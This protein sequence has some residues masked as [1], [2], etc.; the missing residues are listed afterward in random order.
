MN[1]HFSERYQN[2]N[3]EQKRAVDTIDGPVLVIAGPGS[4]KTEL[5]SLR[6]ANILRSTDTLPSS[7]LCLTFTDS[8]AV[9]MRKRLAGLI[10]QEAY[11]V[12]I[13][14]FHS[15]GSEIIN[16]NP[17]FFY[18]GA[19]FNP[20]DELVQYKI[21]EKILEALKHDTL[22]RSYN[23]EQGYTYLRDIIKKIGEL[24]KGGLDPKTLREILKENKNYLE[25]VNGFFPEIFSARM[26]KKTLEQIAGLL[27]KLKNVPMQPRTKVLPYKPIGTQLID[28]LELAFGD[29]MSGEKPDTKPITVW[30]NEYLKKND[31]NLP[32]LKELENIKKHFELCEIYEKYQQELRKEGYFDFDDMLMDTAEVI[33]KNPELRYNLQERYLYVLVDEFQD[34]NAVQMQLLDLLLDAEVNERRPNILAVGDDDQ[35]IYKFQGANLENILNFHQ[36]YLNPEL[37]VLQKNYRSTQPILDLVRKIILTGNERLEARLPDQIKK[38]LQSANTKLTNGEILEKEFQTGFEELAWIA[39]TIKHKIEVEKVPPSEIAVIAPKHKILEETAKVL[40][41]FGIPV[42]YERKKDLLEQKHLREII[43]MLRF[44]ST[45]LLKGQ[46]EADDFLPEI[47]SFEFWGIERLEV[48]KISVQASHERKLWMEVMLSSD[49][50]KIKAIAEFFLDL[51][52][53]AKAGTA[54]EIIDLITGSTQ[55][56]NL[57]D[58]DGMALPKEESGFTE[59]SSKFQS[60]YK[61]YYF[62]NER[63]ENSRLDYLDFLQSLQAFVKKIRQH[64]GTETL[65][66]KDV[67]EFVELHETHHL[68]MHHKSAFNDEEKAVNLMTAHKAKGLEFENV[69]VL[70][71]QEDFWIDRKSDKLSF[72]ANIPLS[73]ESDSVE[74]PLRLFYVTLTRAKRNLYLCRHIYSPK[75]NEQ[76]RLRFLEEGEF[77][78]KKRENISLEQ[79]EGYREE[80]AAN[81]GLEKLLELQFEVSR[82]EVR[83]IDEND[84]L[85][86]LIKNYKLSVT[87]LNN[88]L[89]IVD[90]GPQ[91]FLEQNLLKFPQKLTTSNAFGSAMHAALQ[92]LL[93]TMKRTNEVPE[94]EFLLQEFEKSLLKQR[95]NQKDF[96]H[97]LEKGRD[98]LKIYYEKRRADFNAKD[99]AE[100]DFQQQGVVLGKAEITGK[101]DRIRYDE[102]KKEIL[103]FDYKTGKPLQDWQGKQDFE[104][105]KAW[106]NRNQLIFYKILVEN[107]RDFKG[108][109][110]VRNGFLEFL[111]PI[112]DEIKLLELNISEEETE[113]MKK[114]IQVVYR[115]IVDLDFPDV[116]D[117]EKNVEGIQCFVDNLLAEW[118]KPKNDSDNFDAGAPEFTAQDYEMAGEGL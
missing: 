97:L 100:F 68:S 65:T 118:T 64:R 43:L 7:I 2:L 94:L 116:T 115:K 9:N 76:I 50:E 58:E 31:Q 55:E 59:P 45:M 19:S 113:K 29:S 99:Q 60:P 4:G 67:V 105:I 109:Y 89:N 34:T 3:A 80:Y 71:C 86:G 98:H 96:A 88:F 1:N 30:K 17:E 28:S 61:K 27:E 20:A 49:N 110:K 25:Q 38:E 44:V 72:P 26:S 16:R 85:K 24:K 42:A 73:P 32:S 111:Q 8:A 63:F 36:K 33:A 62:S 95:L 40:D 46:K 14:T 6:V 104:K 53:A 79:V 93:V 90:G 114:L 70:H 18:Q 101:I 11:R 13:H 66:V 22:L 54:E 108:R 12:A 41:Y 78:K 48:W 83:N 82:H 112:N 57:L 10:G 77:E 87:H 106:K 117:Y 92:E 56:K 81:K 21:V 74:D 51:G 37:V 15:F 39:E 75:G 103:V 102:D 5:L 69:F 52:I 107:A 35:A 84:L 23:P 91:K 47:L